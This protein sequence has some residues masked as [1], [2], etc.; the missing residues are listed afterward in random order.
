MDFVVMEK[1]GFGLYCYCAAV[2]TTIMAALATVLG[3]G[4]YC[5]CAA[6]A[7]TTIS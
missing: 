1:V 5:C 6:V 7:T 2:V 4:L 3:Y